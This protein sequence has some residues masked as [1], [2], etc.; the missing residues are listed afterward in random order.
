MGLA[1][2]KS[3][4][5]IQH[6][7]KCVE[8][9]YSA[10]DNPWDLRDSKV[11]HGPV[12]PNPLERDQCRMTAYLP[13]T[14]SAR[15]PHPWKIGD[16]FLYTVEKHWFYPQIYLQGRKKKKV[17]AKTN[18]SVLSTRLKISDWPSGSKLFSSQ[19]NRESPWRS[20]AASPLIWK[21]WARFYKA[22]LSANEATGVFPQL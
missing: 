1:V 16:W 12:R 20:K 8:S 6:Q 2:H 18:H 17:S 21:P 15:E 9:P 10:V 3:N 22:V 11:A 13:P 4:Y 19:L 5:K 7:V 14:I